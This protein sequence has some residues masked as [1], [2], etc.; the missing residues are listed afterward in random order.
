M[1]HARRPST[2]EGRRFGFDVPG[3]GD[4]WRPSSSEAHDLHA[5]V[6]RG[7]RIRRHERPFVAVTARL[8]PS[9]RNPAAIHEIGTNGFRSPVRKDSI[10]F[11][12]A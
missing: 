7:S 12:I 10:E 3:L 9:G 1:R 6:A 2:S 5:T 8:Q 11:G 4:R